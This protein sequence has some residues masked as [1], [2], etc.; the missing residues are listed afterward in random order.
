MNKL[1]NFRDLGGLATTNGKKLRSKRLLRAGQPVNLLPE[2]IIMLQDH[3][4]A[5]I[6]DFRSA[7]E[8]ENEPVDIIDGVE[9]VNLDVMADVAMNWADPKEWTKKLIPEFADSEM[10]SNYTS[11]IHT[12]SSQIGFAEFLRHCAN[13]PEGAI[14]FH[15]AAGKDRTGFAAAIIL[16]ILGI[17]DEDIYTDYMRTLQE[18]KEANLKVIEKYRAYG[19]SESQLEALATM[20]GVK[21]TYLAAAFAAIDEKYQSFNNYIEQGLGI[22]ADDIARIREYY[23]E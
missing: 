23:L 17:A 20:Y 14:L 3:G 19:L 7:F 18:R 8:V 5:L 12:A 16:K 9:Y 11:F 2:E 10:E 1:I 13:M 22:S 21:Q 4:L 6:V 15:C